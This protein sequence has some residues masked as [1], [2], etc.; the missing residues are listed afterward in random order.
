MTEL[1]VGDARVHYRV[2]G[3]GPALVLVHGTG[4][5]SVSWNGTSGLLADR[6]TVLLPDL[7]GSEK[8]EDA[9]GDLTVE[10][11]AEQLA[12][13][14][15]DSDSAPV[16]VLGFSLG[17]VVAAALAAT[18]PELVRRLILVAALSHAEDEYVRTNMAVWLSLSHDAEAFGRYAALTAHSRRYLNDIG[19]E[20]V[21]RTAR[22]MRP[23][24]GVLRQIDLVR[25]VDIRDLL[26]GIQAET[27]VIGCT[28]DAFVP[29]ENVRELHAAIPGSR[30]AEIDSGHVVRLERP[31]EFV[32][33]V[34]EFLEPV[35]T[36]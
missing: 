20:A 18:R 17:S 19:S 23:S 11:L 32:R 1:I 25:R 5:G 7:G 8:A 4:P 30:Y 26:P 16:D 2:E 27:L 6:H 15:E 31:D 29:V 34:R 28:Q 12:A 9:G 35:T 21:E 3:D 10:I 22:F 14:I 36:A 33:V 13:V 24:P